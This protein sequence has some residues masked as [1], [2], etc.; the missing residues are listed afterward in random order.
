MNRESSFRTSDTLI[1]TDR[2]A[3]RRKVIIGVVIAILVIV[4]AAIMFMGG[5]KK[6]DQAAAGGSGAGQ[7]PTVTVVV[8]GQTSVAGV[9]TASGP[10]GAK[11][12]QPVGVAGSGGWITSGG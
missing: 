6:D 2:S 7:V 9:I 3:Q 5:S 12:D 4:V 10:L 8:P 11:R 1:V